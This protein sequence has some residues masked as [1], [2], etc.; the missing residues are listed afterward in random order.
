MSNCSVLHPG[1]RT[2]VGVHQR[3]PPVR[4]QTG[5]SQGGHP[6]WVC[7]RSVGVQ[8]PSGCPQSEWS[9]FFFFYSLS[10]FYLIDGK[11]KGLLMK[12]QQNINKTKSTIC[13]SRAENPEAYEASRLR[14]REKNKT[15]HYKWN[16]TSQMKGKAG[17][18]QDINMK[19]YNWQELKIDATQNMNSKETLG[20]VGV[21]RN[22]SGENLKRLNALMSNRWTSL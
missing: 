21:K 14:K 19:M 22:E 17:A 6:G 4:L 1:A 5:P 10:P 9:F 7:G 13:Q 20:T 12:H 16:W 3:A 18:N 8:Q 2:S 11:K 15:H